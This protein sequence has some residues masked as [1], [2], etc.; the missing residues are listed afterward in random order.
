V[1]PPE[2]LA[3]APLEPTLPASGEFVLASC[4]P[5]ERRSSNGNRSLA[6]RCLTRALC[7][8]AASRGSP[9]MRR[10]TTQ[11]A[12]FNAWQFGLRARSIRF[13]LGC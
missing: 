13:A 8:R 2:L 1:E 12:R 9:R 3:P 5:H 6:S 7:F 4:P 11:R 10:L